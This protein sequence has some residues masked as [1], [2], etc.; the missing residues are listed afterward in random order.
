MNKK[1]N[2]WDNIGQNKNKQ[3]QMIE[4]WLNDW[5]LSGRAQEGNFEAGSYDGRSEDSKTNGMK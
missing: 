1:R 5:N 2:I 3:D 4:K